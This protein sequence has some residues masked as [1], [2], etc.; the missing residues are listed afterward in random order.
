MTKYIFVLLIG[1]IVGFTS[2]KKDKEHTSVLG[3]WNCEE[4][5][6]LG[7]RI[8][9]VTISRDPSSV[10]DTN[11]Y[12]IYNFHQI[13]TSENSEVYVI[14]KEPGILNIEG[15]SAMNISFTGT[16]V[17][18][19]DFSKIEWHYLVNDGETNPTVVA[20]YY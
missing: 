13:G 20:T 11:A 6:E 15:T 19:D 8:Y 2:C 7:Q 4:N 17:V 10:L 12:I 18:A 9:Q 3:A 16:G 5:S 14:E 1:I